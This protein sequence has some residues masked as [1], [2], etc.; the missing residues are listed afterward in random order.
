[1]GWALTAVL[2]VVCV[3]SLPRMMRAGVRGEHY[4]AAR[5]A[6]AISLLTTADILYRAYSDPGSNPTLALGLAVVVL[7]M[8]A[9]AVAMRRFDAPSR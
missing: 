6:A 9:I 4:I 7:T 2:A 5:F 1:M 8:F 3:I